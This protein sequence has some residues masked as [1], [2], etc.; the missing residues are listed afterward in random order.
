MG[1]FTYYVITKGGGGGGGG[2]G[3]YLCLIM[4]EAEVM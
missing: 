2:S 4:G 1:S 3:K